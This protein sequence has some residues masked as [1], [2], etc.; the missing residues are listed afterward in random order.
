MGF[1]NPLSISGYSEIAFF[2]VN[3]GIDKLCTI[4]EDRNP[5]SGIAAPEL[6]P[7]IEFPGNDKLL[8]FKFFILPDESQFN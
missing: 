7:F 1:E 2:G 8:I 6:K 5:S 3:P 4:L